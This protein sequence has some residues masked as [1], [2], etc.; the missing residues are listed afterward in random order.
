MFFN[1]KKLWYRFYF[2]FIIFFL[3]YCSPFPEEKILSLSNPSLKTCIFQPQTRIAHFPM[4]HFPPAGKYTADIREIVSQSQF[5]LFHTV[6]TYSPNVA[7]FEESQTNNKFNPILLE[8]LK[9]NQGHAFT[10]K[11]LSGKPVSVQ[12]LFD[13]ANS[14]FYNGISA[15]YEYLKEDQKEYL[16]QIGASRTLYFLGHIPY[17]FKSIPNAN[18]QIILS[19]VKSQGGVEKFLNSSSPDKNYYLLDFRENQL[20]H[21]VLEFFKINPTFSGLALIAYGGAHNFEDDF[22]GYFF[23][24]GTHCLD[25]TQKASSPNPATVFYEDYK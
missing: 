8:R 18:A 16:F 14:L 9:K 1:L 20:K 12:K 5:Q 21:Q 23:E 11:G 2:L 22:K 25:W 15:Y 17:I 6:L 19:K 3:S 10:T 24:T 7:L 13:T 4:Y